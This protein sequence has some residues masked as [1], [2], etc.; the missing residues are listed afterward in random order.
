MFIEPSKAELK[1]DVDIEN[2]LFTTKGRVGEETE[3]DVNLQDQVSNNV[4]QINGSVLTTQI[5]TSCLICTC[6]CC[7]TTF[8]LHQ[9]G[10]P[11]IGQLTRAARQTERDLRHQPRAQIIFNIGCIYD[12]INIIIHKTCHSFTPTYVNWQGS[13]IKLDIMICPDIIDISL[14]L[15]LN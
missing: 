4:L 3:V 2:C 6:C 10:K 13:I 5:L 14:A 9:L 8:N 12:N 7:H 11:L 1:P 15:S